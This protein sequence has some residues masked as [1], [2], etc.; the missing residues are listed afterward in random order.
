MLAL[1]P[2]IEMRYSDGFFGEASSSLKFV[3]VS[4]KSDK[5]NKNK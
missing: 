5:S 1:A 2:S 3:K 4:F